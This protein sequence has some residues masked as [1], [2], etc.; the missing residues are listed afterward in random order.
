MIFQTWGDFVVASLQQAWDAVVGFVPLLLSAV[1][2]FIIGWIVAVAL[3]KLVEQIIRA[4]RVDMFLAK[5]DFEK[6]LERAGM[7]LNTGAFVGGLVRWFLIIV[8]LLAAANILQLTQVTNFLT[9]VLLYLPNV[10]VA[11]LILVIAALV[12]ETAE[13]VGRG[14]VE[15]LG[16][17]GGHLVAVLARWSVWVF[18]IVAALQQLG[19]ATALLQ[20]FVTGFVAMLALA[21][22]LAFGLGGKDAAGAIVEKMLRDIRGG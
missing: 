19:I 10:V 2:V 1:I 18:A 7:K 13:R 4:L 22:G 11:A 12:A 14:S 16:L 8:T 6:A 20:T 5:L 15:S 3:G 21:L 17:R 9:A